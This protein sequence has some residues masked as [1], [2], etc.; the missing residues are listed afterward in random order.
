MSLF[1]LAQFQSPP[2]RGGLGRLM[3]ARTWP[4]GTTFQSPP[5]RG[6]LGRGRIPKMS[7]GQ[8]LTQA[9]REV[10]GTRLG[11]R[12]LS[13]GSITE[14]PIK[15]QLATC[16]R[17]PVGRTR[18]TPTR[19]TVSGAAKLVCGVHHPAARGMR[20]IPPGPDC[21]GTGAVQHHSK[22]EEPRKTGADVLGLVGDKGFGATT[23]GFSG[24]GRATRSRPRPR[25]RTGPRSGPRSRHGT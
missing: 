19:F 3:L 16:E 12:V 5:S 13:G 15:K 21:Q 22:H 6:G 14:Q 9:P 24:R 20:K 8:K 1:A 7:R 11:Q 4:Y 10:P 25:P 23:S 2:S 17:D 18:L